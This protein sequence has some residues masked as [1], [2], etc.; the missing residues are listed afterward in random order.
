MFVERLISSRGTSLGFSFR[1]LSSSDTKPNSN[2]SLIDLEWIVDTGLFYYDRLDLQCVGYTTR[3]EFV[4]CLS[5]T[6]PYT[7]SSVGPIITSDNFMGDFWK[8]TRPVDSGVCL[9]VCVYLCFI[10]LRDDKS[11]G[12]S[13]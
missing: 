1:V 7:F 3:T 8:Y 11:D 13:L 12:Q 4:L 6:W 10:F 9:C 5:S 2:Y